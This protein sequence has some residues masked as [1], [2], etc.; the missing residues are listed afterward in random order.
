MSFPASVG[1]GWEAMVPVAWAT[2]ALTDDGA[3]LGM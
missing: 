1:V 2:L 3:Y